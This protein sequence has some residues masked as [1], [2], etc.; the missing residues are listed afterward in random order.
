M[1]TPA[2]HPSSVPPPGTID[3]TLQGSMMTS[4]ALTPN[5]LINGYPVRAQYGFN[6]IPMPPGPARVDVSCQWILEYGR[7]SLEFEVRPGEAVPVFY[8]APMHQFSA[9]SIGHEPQKRKGVTATIVAVVGFVILV[10]LMVAL[11]ATL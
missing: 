11:L 4:N 2:E 9:G 7:A 6:R 3:L 10:A 5:V 1:T 8:M